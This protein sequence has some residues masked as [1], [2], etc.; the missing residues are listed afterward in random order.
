M[1]QASIRFV[2][3]GEFAWSTME[4]SE[5][6]YDFD[7]LERAI[8]LAAKA[9]HLCRSGHADRRTSGV[10]DPRN[11]QRPCASRK[12]VAGTSMAIANSSTGPIQ[13]I[14]ELA[15]DI[16]PSGWPSDSVTI[17]NVNRMAD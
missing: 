8:A 16:R 3:I 14:V 12:T 6:R 5:G 17:P 4:P 10:A 2:R 15:R 7:W 11:I 1:E 13:S 9:P